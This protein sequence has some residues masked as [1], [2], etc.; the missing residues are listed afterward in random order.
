MNIFRI[1]PLLAALLLSGACSSG[2]DTRLQHEIQTLV[3]SRRADTG[4]AILLDGRP[5]V[6]VN[7]TRRY[8]LMS[9]FKF[10]Q[11]VAVARR[12]EAQG[13]PLDHPLHI[14]RSE[15]Q[16][17]TYSPLRDRF[18]EQDIDLTVGELLRYSVQYSDN[19]ACDLLFRHIIGVEET[20]ADLR[21]LDIGD[22]AISVDEQT[23]HDD[24]KRCH[25][26]YSTPL[27]AASLLD[28]FL[29]HKAVAAP[30]HAA[31]MTA[32]TDSETG[33][34]RL[35]RPFLSSDILA[36]DKTGTGGRQADGSLLGVNDIG[37]FYLPDDRRCT[38]AVLVGRSHET[39]SDTEALIAD[40]AQKVYDHLRR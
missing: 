37:F 19:N 36:G 30:Y 2:T 7:A 35:R 32:M 3:D 28:R 24:P 40:I 38:L 5:L 17:E 34:A 10:H 1:L 22:F 14:R 15:M 21:R 12:L 31:I 6:L 29:T 18:P 8:P 39:L 4:V 16:K 27:S 20:D 9:V 26:N 23:M 33:Q 11:A 25:D 13:L